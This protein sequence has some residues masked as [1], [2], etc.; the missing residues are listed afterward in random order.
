MVTMVVAAGGPLLVASLVSTAFRAHGRERARTLVVRRTP[1]LPR[2]VT[3]PVER[4]LRDAGL[5]L[6]PEQAVQLWLGTV[7]TVAV[8]AVSIS[9]ALVLP[10]VVVALAGGPIAVRM[11]R[12]RHTRALGVALPAA[13]DTVAA[14]LRA[15]GTVRGAV[16]SLARERGALSSDLARVDARVTLGLSFAD[17]LGRWTVERSGDEVRAVAGALAVADGLGG[18][19]VDALE[20]LA[21][22]LRDA[23]GAAA[24]AR[25]LSAQARLSA[26]VVGGAPLA[27]LAF[28]AVTDPA[29]IGVLVGTAPGQMCLASG[30]AL[31]VLAVVWM[32]R[33][34][35][36]V[37]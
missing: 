7:A 2:W 35:G 36:A 33:I 16:V 37:R 25:A 29:S 21:R 18:R 4:R 9:P 24:E 32:R 19:A 30:L 17:A 12:A 10:G 1:A 6:G 34:V 3:M 5:G 14:E 20:G 13:L 31:E 8:L 23:D 26:M 22:S 11:S 15:G 27:Y 28:Q